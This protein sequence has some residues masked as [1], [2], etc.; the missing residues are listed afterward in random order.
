MRDPYQVLGVARTASAEEIRKAY[1]KLARKHHPDV[2]KSE[3]DAARFTEINAAYDILGDEEKRKLFDEFG[4]VSTRPGFDAARARAWQQG[5][6]G[7]GPQWEFHQGSPGGGFRWSS[8]GPDFSGG[9]GGSPEDLLGSLFGGRRRP[10]GPARGQDLQAEVHVSLREVARNEPVELTIRR[11]V[12]A[13]G[14]GAPTLVLQ[15]QTLKVRLPP[16]VEEG[17]T[18]RLR[19]KG[20]ESPHGGPP[21]D[22][23]LTV[24]IDPSPGLRRDGDNLEL[25]L[26]ITFGEALR[27]GRIT[28]PTFDGEVRLTIPAG[29]SPD[30]RLRL[31]GKGMKLAQG[32]GDLLIALRPV[33]PPTGGAE[34][35]DL[36]GRLDALY[37]AD[38]RAG[39]SALVG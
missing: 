27:G 8:D 12:R 37:P 5:G 18:I 7:G 11:P 4:E 3:A 21:G 22:L 30:Q 26:P 29:A 17:R 14:E 15:E 20:G 19:G 28:V 16:A 31:R 2:A 33:P 24:R 32:R 6:M 35:E 38:V 13:E 1:K 25:D 39:L 9:F 34:V 10:R 23:L 36:A